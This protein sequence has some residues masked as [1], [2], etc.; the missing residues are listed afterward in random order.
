[1]NQNSVSVIDIEKLYLI[2]SVPAGIKPHDI[3]IDHCN[4]KVYI[5]SYEE[6]LIIGYE[7][8]TKKR[9]L[10]KTEGKPIHVDIYKNRLFV[11]TYILNGNV[12]STLN[13]IDTKNNTIKKQCEIKGLVTNIKYDPFFDSVYMINIEDRYLYCAD[14]LKKEIKKIVF[15]GGYPEDIVIG[16]KKIFITNSKKKSL[17][18][19]DRKSRKIEDCIT[20]GFSP[21]CIILNTNYY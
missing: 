16:N 3:V 9:T 6:N 11:L 12:A 17:I 14:L 2:E 10:Y 4:K 13:I 20:L 19:I 21:E 1:M 15:L 5:A 7:N 18:I 8:N